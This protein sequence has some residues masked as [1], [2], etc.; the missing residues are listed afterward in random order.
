MLMVEQIYKRIQ[1]EVER[2]AGQEVKVIHVVTNLL[3]LIRYMSEK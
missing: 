2:I 3:S 1:I